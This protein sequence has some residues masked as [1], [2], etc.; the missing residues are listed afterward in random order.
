MS[1]LL[2]LKSLLLFGVAIFV[3]A[4][5]DAQSPAATASGTAAG[6]AITIT[7]H[8]PAVKGRKIWGELVPYGEVWRTG[9]NEATIFET[10]KDITIGG[11]TVK[12][13]KYSLYTLPG[14]KEWKFILNSETG[15]W[16]INN[17]GSTTDDSSKDVLSTVVTPM[18]SDSFNERML[19]KV[20]D[21]GIVLLWENLAV[22]VPIK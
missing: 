20:N 5:A 12:A 14:E 9:A 7:Y 2:T 19:F 18:K 17:D 21:D 16:G 1:K 8:S 3:S 6:S 10:S 22:P 11:K 4:A 15:Q 13:G